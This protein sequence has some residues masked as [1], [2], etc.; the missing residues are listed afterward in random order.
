MEITKA[1]CRIVP[2]AAGACLLI[3]VIGTAPAYLSL[4]DLTKGKEIYGDACAA[5][6][7]DDGRG[8][9]AD[10]ATE[11]P[12][13]DLTSCD[14]NTS[15]ADRDWMRVVSG[16]GVA[17]GRSESMPSFRDSLTEEDIK[18]VVVYLRTFCTEDWPRGELNFS[19]PLVT[20]KAY[21]E[22]EA[23]LTWNTG[24][25]PSREHQTKLAAIIEKRVGARGQVE[26][27]IPVSL[28][29]PDKRG[30]LGGIGDLEVSGKYVLYHD[31]KRLFIAS[32]GAE[33]KLP[34]GSLRRALGEGTTILAPFLAAGKGWGDFVVQSSLQFEYPFVEQRAPKTA[35]YNLAFSYPVVNR[36]EGTEGQL[37][38]EFNGKSEWGKRDAKHFQLYLTPGFRQ[39]LTA[40]GNWAAAIGAQLPVSPVHEAQYRVLGYILFELPP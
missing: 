9:V 24:R 7:G 33:L 1:L 12:P 26:L 2:L 11:V 20:E 22:N 25:T 21:P 32:A 30:T 38:L 36:G 6:H 31:L 15:E 40:S 8:K 18:N 29:D 14:F 13:P 4:I 23:L 39:S 19:R 37:F 3:L 28:R 10:L 16:G 34:T 5:C 17:A 35:L 27:K